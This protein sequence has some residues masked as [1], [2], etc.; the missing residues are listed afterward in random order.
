[1]CSTTRRIKISN[2][3]KNSR[4]ICLNGDASLNIYRTKTRNDASIRKTIEKKSIKH[5]GLKSF[6]EANV[7][8]K[9]IKEG[10]NLRQK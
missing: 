5:L 6:V 2:I 9:S 8:R 4:N 3:L 7:I 10:T 1:M